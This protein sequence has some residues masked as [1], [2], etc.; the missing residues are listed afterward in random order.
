MRYHRNISISHRSTKEQKEELVDKRQRYHVVA[1]VTFHNGKVGIKVLP[2]VLPSILN[3]YNQVTKVK[4]VAGVQLY[5][6]NDIFFNRYPNSS[7]LKVHF[8]DES[9][10]Q[11][12]LAT[13]EKME[14]DGKSIRYQR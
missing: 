9:T 8:L 7:A 3:Y 10:I 4:D 11:E 13:A 1:V 2:R 12:H 5:M 14:C 6:S